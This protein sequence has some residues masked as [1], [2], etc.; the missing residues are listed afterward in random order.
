MSVTLEPFTV[1]IGDEVLDDLRA[2]IRNT[3]WP[4]DE[5]P[6]VGWEQG[7]DLTKLRVVV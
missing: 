7:T 3:R 2:R 1:H 6:G 5:V 4:D